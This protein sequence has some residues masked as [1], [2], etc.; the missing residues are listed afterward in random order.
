MANVHPIK[1]EKYAEEVRKLF[2]RRRG[3][4][5]RKAIGIIPCGS[6]DSQRERVKNKIR[7]MF[8]Y[9]IFSMVKSKKIVYNDPRLRY[10]CS[11]GLYRRR[12]EEI[13]IS[14]VPEKFLDIDNL[15]P[16]FNEALDKIIQEAQTQIMANRIQAVTDEAKG[17]D[18]IPSTR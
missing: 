7:D 13:S 8:R 6:E 10:N 3:A 4:Y 11:T 14:D 5:I 16:E 18:D 15:F 9:D 2:G 12:E 17:K 1:M